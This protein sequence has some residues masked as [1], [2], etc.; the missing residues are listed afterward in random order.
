MTKFLTLDEV[1][2]IFGVTTFTV[3]RWVKRGDF[4]KPF[5]ISR[6]YIRWDAADIERFVEQ[7]KAAACGEG[8]EK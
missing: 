3:G 4:P 5:R 8:I 6:R 1:A 2:A 7:S